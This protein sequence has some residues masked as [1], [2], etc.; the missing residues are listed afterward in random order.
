MKSAPFSYAR[1]RTRGAALAVLD[2]E[3]EARALAGGQ[4]LLPL[5]VARLAAPAVLVDLE[6]VD[7]LT[8]V[9]LDGG[10]VRIGAMTRQA[11]AECSELLRDRFP[12][13]VEGLRQV[14]YP[15][16]RNRGTVG[17]SIAHADPA[18]ELPVLA[19]ALDASIV[20]DGPRG[21]HAVR[22][23][24]FFHGPFDPALDQGELVTSVDLP[25]T[26]LTWAFLELA[27]R[28]A[29]FAL[30]SVAVGLRMEG[31][32][33]REARIV[34]GAAHPRPIRL[35]DAEEALVG[36]QIDHE[37]ADAV[38]RRAVAA[39]RPASDVGGSA[40]Y[41]REVAAVLARRAILRA[42]GEERR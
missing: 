41:R 24:D 27:R 29:D 8:G 20:V 38:A 40:E 42:A 39:L 31:G 5:M 15:S 25:V 19:V 18:A 32:T 22:A 17:G 10:T 33:C 35:V 26:D 30:V 28:S 2:A 12:V 3:P 34:V 6:G 16:I 7:D 4:S 37:T 9:R 1:P 23:E 13:L 21:E 11:D 14:G 36:Q